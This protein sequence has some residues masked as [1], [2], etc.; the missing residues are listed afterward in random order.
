MYAT[1]A[2]YAEAPHYYNT[3]ALKYYTTT[4]VSPSYYTHVL[5]YYCASKESSKKK[6]VPELQCPICHQLLSS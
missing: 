3:E 6:E 5:K 4:C 2:Y 1:P